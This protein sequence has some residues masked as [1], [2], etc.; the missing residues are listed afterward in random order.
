MGTYLSYSDYPEFADLKEATS[1]LPG[2]GTNTTTTNTFN[3]DGTY[4][5]NYGANGWW[6]TNTTTRNNTMADMLV[7]P[8]ASAQDTYAGFLKKRAE[9]VTQSSRPYEEALFAGMSYGNPNLEQDTI[10]QAIP[11]VQQSIKDSSGI[12]DRTMGS[13]GMA[14]DDTQQRLSDRLNKLK[15]SGTISQ[16]AAMI[17]QRLKDR[18]L[19]TALGTGSSAAYAPI[20]NA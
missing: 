1:A 7:D 19:G 9:Y 3:P 11:Q 14:Y 17:K 15:E 5:E 12:I 8:N 10:N 20:K 2:Y 4:D 13:A 16:T 6:D 18:D